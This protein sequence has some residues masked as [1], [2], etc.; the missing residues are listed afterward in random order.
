MIDR[1]MNSYFPKAVEPMS[2]AQKWSVAAN[3]CA[4]KQQ[5]LKGKAQLRF[6]FRNEGENSKCC[7]FCDTKTHIMVMFKF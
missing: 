1:S 4:K 5:G 7:G 2:G 3:F 6:Y